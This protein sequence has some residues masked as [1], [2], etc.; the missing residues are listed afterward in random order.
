MKYKKCIICES[1]NAKYLF[2]KDSVDI[3]KCR[4]CGLIYSNVSV[5]KENILKTYQSA[6]Y[7]H[8]ENDIRYGYHDYQNEESLHSL[9]FKKRLKNINEYIPSGKLLDVGCA[10]GF[11]L[12]VAKEHK[13]DTY[14]V[15]VS[16]YAAEYAEKNS[17]ADIFNGTIEDVRYPD[18]FFDVVIMEDVIEHMINP[19]ASLKKIN[20][21][22]KKGGIAAINTP[23]SRGLLCKI[24]GRYWPHYKPLEHL[25]F[26]L[27]K[28]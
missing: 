20:E 28:P 22:M 6:N 15:E 25:Y 2:T 7:F 16:G 8:N 21:L 23:N 17:G 19:V 1:E 14:G 18:S 13:W 9:L 4:I 27:Q 5:T 24:S 3:V 12:K 26:S 11:F 10:M